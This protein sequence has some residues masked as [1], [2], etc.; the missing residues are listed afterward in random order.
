MIPVALPLFTDTVVSPQKATGLIRYNLPPVKPCWL[1]QIT[2][3][4]MCINISSGGDLLYDLSKQRREVHWP[5]VPWVLLLLLFLFC[6]VFLRKRER[7]SDAP[8]FSV[9]RDF[10]WWPWFFKCNCR[11]AW[12]PQTVHTGPWDA[13]HP[14][15]YTFTHSASWGGLGHALCL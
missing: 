2:L 8:L 10:T 1:S 9:T 6:F 14:A 7:K 3:P 13:S 5:V 4:S 11:V 12:Q 15:P